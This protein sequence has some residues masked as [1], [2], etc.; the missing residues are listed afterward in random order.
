MQV[1]NF[2]PTTAYGIHFVAEGPQVSLNA[3]G[4]LMTVDFWID[5]ISF[6]Q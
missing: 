1:A 4:T 6:V 5:D 3:G 2:D